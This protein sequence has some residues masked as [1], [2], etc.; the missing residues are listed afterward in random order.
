MG[1]GQGQGHVALLEKY[2]KAV[3]FVQGLVSEHFTK[4]LEM[5]QTTRLATPFI[6]LQPHDDAR[7][8]IEDQVD[9]P[10]FDRTA[11]EA[12][13]HFCEGEAVE[14]QDMAGLVQALLWDFNTNGEHSLEVKV[15]EIYQKLSHRHAGNV[16]IKERDKFHTYGRPLF[17]F[18]WGR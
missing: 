9:W 7:S 3:S 12:G 4:Q 8:T 2:P 14:V 13:I 11:T 10:N 5:G 1:G 16:Y 18:S 15:R 6:C 17:Q